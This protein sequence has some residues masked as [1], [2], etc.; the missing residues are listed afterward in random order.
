WHWARERTAVDLG[1]GRHSARC[2]HG[3]Y[4]RAED[5]KCRRT[6]ESRRARDH[7]RTDLRGALGLLR[8]AAAR[9]ELGLWAYSCSMKAMSARPRQSYA[10]SYPLSSKRIGSIPRER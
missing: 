5:R 7:S 1:D 9:R 6:F 4:P 3:N 8:L 2:Q 10:V